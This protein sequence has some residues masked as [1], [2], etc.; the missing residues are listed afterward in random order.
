MLDSHGVTPGRRQAS[1]TCSSVPPNFS[2]ET[3]EATIEGLR[4]AS[5]IY[6][7]PPPRSGSRRGDQLEGVGAVPQVC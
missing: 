7:P 6:S 2:A 3:E 4:K 1:S 5:S